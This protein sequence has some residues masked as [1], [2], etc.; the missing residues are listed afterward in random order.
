MKSLSLSGRE[1]VPNNCAED[2]IALSGVQTCAEEVQLSY[3]L[4]PLKISDFLTG[5]QEE[6]EDMYYPDVALVVTLEEPEEMNKH[7]IS[8]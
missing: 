2:N 3:R 1:E 5:K 4:L 7:C 6:G 8:H